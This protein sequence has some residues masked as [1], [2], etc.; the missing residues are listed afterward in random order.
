MKRHNNAN[1]TRRREK[2]TIQGEASNSF[3]C[4]QPPTFVSFI[5]CNAI[6]GAV[7]RVWPLLARSILISRPFRRS[8]TL[9]VLPCPRGGLAVD[10]TV[11]L[12]RDVPQGT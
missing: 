10:E 5:Q 8:P 11:A 7:L 4:M 2:G 12:K 9:L 3:Q 6:D 1:A